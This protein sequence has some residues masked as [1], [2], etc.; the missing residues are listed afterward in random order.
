MAR[1]R[2]A[3]MTDASRP[4]VAPHLPT[5]TRE[6]TMAWAGE[7]ILALTIELGK[8]VQP[9]GTAYQVTGFTTSRTLTGPA[10]RTAICQVGHVTV[11]SNGPEHATV[12]FDDVIDPRTTPANTGDVLATLLRDLKTRGWLG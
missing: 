10:A 5:P 11:V 7:F 2:S 1:M 9:I 6:L 8:I 3:G 12:T 4:V